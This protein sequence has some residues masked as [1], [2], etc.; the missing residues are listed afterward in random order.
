MSMIPDEAADFADAIVLGNAEGVWP[1]VVADAAAGRLQRVYTG[2]TPPPLAGLSTRWELFAGKR[3]LPV[4]LTQFSR[5]CTYACD[6]CATAVMS[7]QQHTC[8]PPAEVVDE[9][10]AQPAPVIFFVDD[11]LIA[12]PEAA[13][14][15]F[16]Q[17]IPLKRRWVSQASINFTDD[18]ELME[19]MQRSGCAGLVVGFESLL[20]ANLAQMGKVCNPAQGRYDEALAKIRRVGIQ[21]WAALVFG[22]DSDTETSIRQTVEWAIAQKFCFA[23]FNILT[24]YPA[25][26]LYARLQANGQLLYDKWWLHPDYRF[27]DAVFQPARMTPEQLTEACFAAR[28]C[29]SHPRSIFSRLWD[30]RTNAKDLWSLALYCQYN[31]LFRREMLRKHGMQLGYFDTPPTP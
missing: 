15:L 16:R 31:P 26:P 5:G 27:G 28:R 3:Y 29:F 22:Y 9:L 10:R 12:N 8:R 25:T 4:R 30:F 20:P 19:L 23:A 17:L 1:D 24:P 6:Y 13:K 21:L 11:N 7:R 18:P 2:H 14:E